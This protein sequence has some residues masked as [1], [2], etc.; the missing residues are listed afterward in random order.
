MDRLEAMAMFVATVD[1]GSLAAAAR[2]LACSPAKVT[3]AL[4]MLEERSGERLIH[5]NARRLRLTDAG[6]RR[7]AVY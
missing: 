4:Q 6:E 5:R 3:R 1:Q 2:T 7:L